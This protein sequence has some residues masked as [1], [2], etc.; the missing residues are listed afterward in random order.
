MRN[1][2]K[3]FIIKLVL[4][5]VIFLLPLAALDLFNKFNTKI[6]RYLLLM[7]I[8]SVIFLVTIFVLEIRLMEY[9][10]LFKE[11]LRKITRSFSA[12][13]SV[14][15][16]FKSLDSMSNFEYFLSEEIDKLGK[17]FE[18]NN[19]KIIE[20]E[21]ENYTKFQV[22]EYQLK[23][24][25]KELEKMN[26]RMK[27]KESILDSYVE[28]Q[29]EMMNSVKNYNM[30]FD[31]VLFF[32][33]KKLKI[34]DIMVVRY[35]MQ[36]PIVYTRLSNEKKLSEFEL[37]ELKKC[38]SGLYYKKEINAIL[39]YEVIFILASK[40]YFHGYIFING[41][42]SKYLEYPVFMKIVSTV[43]MGILNMADNIRE[44]EESGNQVENLKLRIGKLNME[45]SKTQEELETQLGEISNMYEEIVT[46][47]EVGKSIVRVIDI[48]EIETYILDMMTDIIG[49]ESAY[50]FYFR[51][52]REQAIL[53]NSF[54]KNGNID[55]NFLKDMKIFIKNS[56]LY[57]DLSNKFQ[58]IV[59]NK[60]E[61]NDYAKFLSEYLKGN[62]LNML[63]TPIYY[64]EN[65][66]GGI[67]LCNKSGGE[68]TAG[69]I[70]LASALTNQL[71]I[72]AQNVEFLEKEIQIKKEEEQLKIASD[73]QAKLFPAK[74]PEIS[75]FQI[76]GVS[77]PAKSVGG[78][79]YD[80]IKLSDNISIG[81][82]ADVSGKGVPAA[83][84]VSMVRT[85][86]RMVVFENNSLEP[87]EILKRINMVLCSEDLDGRF[88]TAMCF[89][90]ISDEKII[91]LADA[92]HGNMLIYRAG[93]KAIENFESDSTVLGIMAEEEYG[94]V[95]I[96][97]MKDDIMLLYTD[98]VTD[99][100]EINGEF[101]GSER[102]E[103]I[104]KQENKYP[105]EFI[106][107]R[108]YRQVFKF[109]NGNVQSDDITIV[110]VK[111]V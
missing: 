27:R 36:K 46:L 60:I 12:E 42:S 32:L 16:K 53:K 104:L 78:D 41:L 48:K 107:R 1:W 79:Y 6:Y 40:R 57:Y 15:E 25:V 44:R 58:E 77:F 102:L 28:M 89:K 67:I 38:S 65:I 17:Y 52:D 5:S 70:S 83:L 4:L 31:E 55:E 59:I 54:F 9:Y 82:I 24:V 72:A 94:T 2:K 33:E 26:D 66:I 101:F 39:G 71:G 20:L 18:Q 14:E 63:V 74:F 35:D 75:K 51:K 81:I 47:Y 61:R 21:K 90:I 7:I 105:A 30:F 85:I 56:S 99:E 11:K 68:F 111:G 98:G 10:S 80:I 23:S 62:L 50:L 92:G 87:G 64:G 110:T 69:N 45:L 96:P 76:F 49:T 29:E 86:F 88:V 22:R 106:T 13:N 34:T 109:L 93:K 108:I 43:Y 37:E 91:K 103:E 100:R 73:I 8:E 3:S 97:I 95:S 84:L 19:Q